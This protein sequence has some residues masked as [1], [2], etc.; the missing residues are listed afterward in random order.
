[1]F[2]LIHCPEFYIQCERIFKPELNNHALIIISE[3]D[4]AKVIASSIEA[5]ELGLF[6]GQHGDQ[7][8]EVLATL[9]ADQRITTCRANHELY[10]DLSSRFIKSVELLA[11]K[12][13]IYANDEVVLELNKPEAGSSYDSYA[14]ELANTLDRWLGISVLIGI[15]PTHTLARLACYSP[16][17]LKRHQ[18]RQRH[19]IVDL[20]N[21]INCNNLLENTLITE[22]RG[23]SKKAANKLS[24]IQ[25]HTALELSKAPKSQIRHLSSVII[26][27]IALEL[28]GLPCKQLRANTL[29]Q[30]TNS[31]IRHSHEIHTVDQAKRLLKSLIINASERLKKVN[32]SCQKVT[33]S[34]STTPLSQQQH[35]RITLTADL[36]KPINTA[37]SITQLAN[38]LLESL[39]YEGRQ[40]HSLKLTLEDLY[41]T[42]SNQFGLFTCNDELGQRPNKLE[43]PK[44]IDVEA[45][46][47]TNTYRKN[48]RILH[49]GR[50]L[51]SPSF[52]TKWCD[53]PRVN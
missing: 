48:K 17:L 11:P 6:A 14:Q 37:T 47:L 4:G 13:S 36:P 18:T 49:K 33:V 3:H 42:F 45:A 28:A 22:I 24:Q 32:S 51:L 16:L 19:K 53:I 8:K 21:P 52:T 34:L 41:P 46:L 50:S 1:M 12:V 5:Q 10:S 38:Q 9:T 26:E 35:F 20:S 40:Y 23:I 43:S 2:A 29:K 44:L 7:L 39:W 30:N 25:V 15:A 27:R 31:I